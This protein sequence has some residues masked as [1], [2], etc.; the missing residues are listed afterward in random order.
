MVPGNRPLKLM[1][2]YNVMPD[3]SKLKRRLIRHGGRSYYHCCL[4]ENHFKNVILKNTCLL[5]RDLCVTMN[6]VSMLP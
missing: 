4:F 2:I 1:F 3:S 5:F 6:I